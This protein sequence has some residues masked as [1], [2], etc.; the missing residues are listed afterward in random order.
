MILV[1]GHDIVLY[2]GSH[3]A[4]SASSFTIP[5]GKITAVIGPNGSGKTTLL[6]AIAGILSPSA[7]EIRVMGKPVKTRHLICH[8]VTVFP[9]GTPSPL[10]MSCQ[11]AGTPSAA[12][13]ACS[14]R[15]TA[16]P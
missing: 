10:K 2:R 13:L 15:M 11:W 6:Q 16:R 12:G 14:V 3:R 9:T 1:E 5:Q 7:G 8:A 4:V